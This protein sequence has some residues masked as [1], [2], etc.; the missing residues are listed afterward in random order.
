MKNF[1]LS[2]FTFFVVTSAYSQKLPFQGKLIEGGTPVDG[3]RTIEFSIASPSWNETHTNV[4]I[5]D[6]LY[7]VVLGSNSPLP[8]SIFYETD[9][10]QLEI[11]VDG[12]PLS[13]VI[14]FKPLESPFEGS[15]LN[16]RNDDGRIVGTLKAR[17]DSL[18]HGEFNLHG[19]GIGEIRS[20][21]YQMNGDSISDTPYMMLIKDSIS[22]G[23]FRVTGNSNSTTGRLQ[24]NSNTNESLNITSSAL[25]GRHNGRTQYNLQKSTWN[26]TESYG[27]L[28]LWG[29]NTY[30]F[31]FTSQTWANRDL[32][33]F[34]MRGSE[35][36]EVLVLSTENNSEESGFIRLVNKRDT[37]QVYRE[38]NLNATGLKLWQRQNWDILHEAVS[39]R[40][41]NRDSLGWAGY[42]NLRGPNS[43]NMH[44]GTRSWDGTPDLPIINLHGENDFHGMELTIAPDG[45]GQ[46]QG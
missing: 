34:R 14:L 25:I 39:L 45:N 29:P 23:N 41:E 4:T 20:G 2:L 26:G 24:L 22:Y 1:L 28:R 12:T 36:Q 16:V 40:A 27:R 13:P 32:P 30:N 42:L 6:G 35:N 7:F 43:S 10:Q 38:L 15:E 31:E 9:E 17:T 5:T 8:D 33:H 21:F 18:K 37:N 11:T 44:F 3:S 46:Q 19:E